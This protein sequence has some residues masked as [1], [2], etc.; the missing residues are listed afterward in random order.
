MSSKRLPSDS[1]YLTRLGQALLMAREE[2]GFTQEQL[3][4]EAELDRTYISDLERG[5]RNPTIR[6]LL[7]LSRALGTTP[8]ALLGRVETR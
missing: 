6:S 2:Q 5:K 1:T 7:N 4:F 8:G 3:G